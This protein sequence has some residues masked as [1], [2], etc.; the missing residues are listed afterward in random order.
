MDDDEL[1]QLFG[2]VFATPAGNRLIEALRAHPPRSVGLT[3][4]E[5]RVGRMRRRWK[6][7]ARDDAG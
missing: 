1:D 5:E 6:T 4:I 2:E 3:E 7:G